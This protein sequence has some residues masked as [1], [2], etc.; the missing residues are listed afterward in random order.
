MNYALKITIKT[1]FITSLYLCGGCQE[2]T[3][4]SNSDGCEALA[5]FCP[6]GTSCQVDELGNSF[7]AR[8]EDPPLNNAGTEVIGGS[9]QAGTEMAGVEVIGG[10][11]EAGTEMAGA[12]MAGAEMAGA[13]MAGTE[14]A[15]TEMAGT[16]MAGTEPVMC[17][18]FD[19]NLKPSEASIPQVMLVVDRSYSMVNSEDRWTPALRAISQVTQALDAEVS[20]GLTLFPDPTSNAVDPSTLMACESWGRGTFACEEDV[21]ACAPGRV[22]VNS[23]VNNSFNVREA[24]NSYPPLPNQ[25]TPTYSALQEAADALLNQESSSTERVIILVTDGMPG[26]NFGINPNSCICLTS[27]PF[28]CELDQFAGMCLD[29][30]R[31]TQEITRLAGLGIK[32]IVVGITIGL[33]NEGACINGSDCPYGGQACI[34]NSCVNLA[35]TVLSA[36]A[37]AGGDSSGDYYSVDNLADIESQVTLATASIAPCVF[38]I[39]N[40]PA[41][42]YDQLVVYLDGTVVPRDPNRMNGWWAERGV[43]EFYGNTCEAIRDGMSHRIAARCE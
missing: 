9:S 39:Q 31:T 6:T 11:S 3:T 27:A 8:I 18:T 1:L 35:P 23:A 26:C 21:G 33:P 20:F 4:S 17:G 28:F 2:N 38:D 43:L 7:C 13:E 10:S 42:V 15:G 14:T 12:E 37:R 24:L 36:M 29:D 22:M 30:D 40:I 5:E 19:T 16:E 32:T 41:G 25:A 34:N